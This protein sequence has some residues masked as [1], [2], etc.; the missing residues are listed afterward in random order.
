MSGGESIALRNCY[1]AELAG[2]HRRMTPAAARF[3]GEARRFPG[4]EW[5]L[6]M[7]VLLGIT[8]LD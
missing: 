1:R 4:S 8:P 3:L 6:G 7:P 5:I 2:Y